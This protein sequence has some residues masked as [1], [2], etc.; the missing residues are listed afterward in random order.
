[1]R[2]SKGSEETP[3]MGPTQKI[4]TALLTIGIIAVP[5]VTAGEDASLFPRNTEVPFYY[6]P[7]AIRTWPIIDGKLAG[8]VQLTARQQ[9]RVLAKGLSLEFHGLHLT[10]TRTGKL[11]IKSVTD[12]Q[13]IAFELEV[14]LPNNED[15]LSSQTLQIRV[16]PPQRPISY[17]ADLVDDIIHIYWDANADRFRPITADGFHQYFRRLQAHGINRLI[18]W[19]SPFPYMCDPQEFV[20]EDW[21]RYES[22]ARAI[23][24]NEELVK[25]MET[26]SGQQAWQWLRE[27][28]V[29]RLRPEFGPMFT[30]SAKQHGIALTASFRPFEHAL[31]KYYEVPAFDA[32]GEYL[33]GFLPLASPV[34]NYRPDQVGFSHFREVLARMGKREAAQLETVELPEVELATQLVERFQAGRRDIKIMATEFPPLDSSSWVL[35]RGA[36]MEFQLRK[37]RDVHEIVDAQ[38]HQLTDYK[39]VPGPANAL[40]ITN[41]KVP[42]DCRFLVIS[43]ASEF[44]KSLQLSAD[45]GLT[46]RATAGNRIGRG[47][48]IYWALDE[49]D[50]A[51]R[52]TRVGAILADGGFRAE[53]QATENSINALVKTNADK[54]VMGNHQLVIDL[55]RRWEVEM[56]DF[57][58][59]AARDY[60]VKQLRTLLSYKAFDEILINTRTH[61]DLPASF[62]DGIGG[63]KTV[64]DFRKAGQQR[65]GHRMG[66][67]T[68][69]LLGIDGAYAPIR[70]ADQQQLRELASDPNSVEQITA[71]QP[72]EWV[73]ACQ[74]A[75][76]PFQWRFRRNEAVAQGVRRLLMDLEQTFPKTR[77]RAVIPQRAIVDEAM[78]RGLA[79]MKKPDGGLYGTDFYRHVWSTNNFTYRTC[80]GMA[81]L[82]LSGMRVEPVF[83]GIRYIP[84]DGPLKLFVDQCIVDMR[85]NHGSSFRG[86][87]SFFYEAQETLYGGNREQ[88]GARR[89]AIIRRLLTNHK[90][91]REVLLYEAAD[92]TSH[93]PLDNPH[94]YL[95]TP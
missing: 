66:P 49:S 55:G 80:D 69:L 12:S 16:A 88:A 83:L 13:P 1:M 51:G 35:M 71:S 90:D 95:D 64:F 46:L 32:Q 48:N 86:P 27:I 7:G 76:T 36:D 57:N 74:S 67:S 38:R 65:G 21:Q 45:A 29:L 10:V 39:L 93:L 22:Q 81:M 89:E 44:G 42:A 70:V 58:R 73:G 62:G 6:V 11:A 23:A 92:W 28:L 8:P 75:E 68:F 91:I 30:D 31:T 50:P 17:V 34:V 61:T 84:E 87:R 37:F 4:L 3:R 52:S 53:F 14:R 20:A 25:A 94:D 60:A 24:N 78:K 41:I 9:D 85:D 77:I 54:L 26:S 63:I 15:A 2:S 43:A 47:A 18:V 59:Q 5:S 19:Q 72:G 33:W 56:V 40:R 82:D 79:Q